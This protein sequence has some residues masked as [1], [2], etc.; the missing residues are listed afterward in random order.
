LCTGNASKRRALARLGA[1]RELERS[2]SPEKHMAKYGLNHPKVIDLITSSDQE[3]I[4]VIVIDETLTT[5][6]LPALQEKLN[7]YMTFALDGECNKK[8]PDEV[9]KRIVIQIDLQVKPSPIVFEAID[10][11]A[12]TASK[13]N[14][15]VRSE[16]MY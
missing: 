11:A 2:P 3:L 6:H 14:I 16:I 7:W 12:E 9:G 1:A 4:L 5:S 10:V 13:E 15:L 8:Y